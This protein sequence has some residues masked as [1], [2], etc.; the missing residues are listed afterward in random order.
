MEVKN[1]GAERATSGVPEAES[2][3]LLAWRQLNMWLR[4]CNGG[5]IEEREEEGE[6]V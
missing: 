3:L 2:H 4:W 1:E 5:G 6:G